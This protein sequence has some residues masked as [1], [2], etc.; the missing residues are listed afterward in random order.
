MGGRCVHAVQCACGRDPCGGRIGKAEARAHTRVPI[1][2]RNTRKNNNNT[3]SK[4]SASECHVMGSAVAHP[5][6]RAP[7][8]PAPVALSPEFANPHTRE[9]A[10]AHSD[11]EKTRVRPART[12]RLACPLTR[13]W[14]GS[15]IP[16]R[17]RSS[18][19]GDMPAVDAA[20]RLRLP[21]RRHA[22]RDARARTHT[23]AHTRTHMHVERAHH[24]WR[25]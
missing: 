22:A 23:H 24:G 5:A 1:R 10:S 18:T 16:R 3:P 11:L 7:S 14:P 21:L 2:N 15:P 4:S 8:F 12:R 17:G 20:F 19:T 9:W 25:Y 13:D 6:V